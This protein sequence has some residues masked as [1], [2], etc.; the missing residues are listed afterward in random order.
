MTR[1]LTHHEF[2]QIDRNTYRTKK[3]KIRTRQSGLEVFQHLRKILSHV[4]RSIIPQFFVEVHVILSHID[5]YKR[6]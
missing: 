2:H 3:D 6:L 4:R 1:E 5:E